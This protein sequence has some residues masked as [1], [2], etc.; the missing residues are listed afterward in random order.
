MPM[1]ESTKTFWNFEFTSFP[2]RAPIYTDTRRLTFNVR[3]LVTQSG[4]GIN[5]MTLTIQSVN[6]AIDRVYPFVAGQLNKRG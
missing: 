2:A 4:H 6:R 5:D 3:L 1:T